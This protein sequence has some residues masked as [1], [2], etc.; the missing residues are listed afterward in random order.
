MVADYYRMNVS[1]MKSIL[2]I[3][4]VPVLAGWSFRTGLGYSKSEQSTSPK[5]V[6]T[7]PPMAS[8]IITTEYESYAYHP[9]VSLHADI[10]DISRNGWGLNFSL[11]HFP[12]TRLATYKVAS[13]GTSVSGSGT[14]DSAK[15]GSTDF[16]ISGG[17][18]WK[19]FYMRMGLSMAIVNLT[20]ATGYVGNSSTGQGSGS[21]FAIGFSLTEH[22]DLEA[23]GTSNYFDLNLSN[24]AST[25]KQNYQ[26]ATTEVILLYKF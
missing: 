6:A 9:T 17:Y 5:I 14:S 16:G 23:S 3:S 13:G 1:V 12:Q 26:L 4:L 10:D 11:R 2:A 15:L 19:Y 24:G 8:C 22:L 18:G 7:C 21:V 25:L 20:P